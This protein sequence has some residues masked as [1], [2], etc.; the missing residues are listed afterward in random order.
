M[1]IFFDDSKTTWNFPDAYHEPAS[2]INNVTVYNPFDED[3][4]IPGEIP[5]IGIPGDGIKIESVGN[6]TV[7]NIDW[8]EWYA[9]PSS[10]AAWFG[11]GFHPTWLP[12]DELV[13]NILAD[14]IQMSLEHN[15]DRLKLI[16]NIFVPFLPHYRMINMTA[17]RFTYEN[18]DS[19]YRIW[20]LFIAYATSMDQ[21]T[22]IDCSFKNAH[23]ENNLLAALFLGTVNI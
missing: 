1:S 17:L 8:R 3:E 22:F 14:N 20:P 5:H 4:Y 13:Q 11:Y 19:D 21:M 16:F 2:I 6:V 7:T 15:K 12:D 23:H 18:V 10:I 9:V